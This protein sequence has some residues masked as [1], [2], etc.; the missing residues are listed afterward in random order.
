MSFQGKA[1]LFAA[2]ASACLYGMRPRML[3]AQQVSYEHA[4]PAQLAGIAKDKIGRAHV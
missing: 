3:E 2:V 1:W 4:T